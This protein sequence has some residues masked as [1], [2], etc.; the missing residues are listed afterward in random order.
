MQY[1]LM[2]YK[3]T[4]NLGNEIQSI[5][6]RRFLPKIDHYIDHEE[7]H[8]FNN[9]EKVKMIMNGW[10]LDTLEAWPPSSDIDPLLISMHFNTSVNE[11]KDVILSEKSRDFFSSYGPVGCRDPSTLEL[12][13][14]NDIDAYYSGCL[15]LTL[16][17]NN[18][19]YK[20][21]NPYIAVNV[22]KPWQVIKYLKT[23]TDMPIYDVYQLTFNS[24]NEDY[25]KDKPDHYKLT[26]FYT[27][28]E[29]MFQAE[30]FL[31]IYENA[32]CVI[33]DRLHCALPCLAL[34]TPVLFID[35]AQYG[36]ERLGGLTDLVRKATFE[37]YKNDYSIF[38]VE[39]PPK[40]PDDYIKLR[41]DLIKRTKEF[42]GHINDSY[43]MNDSNRLYNNVN[44]LCKTSRKTKKYMRDVDGI[45]NDYQNEIEKQKQTI[46]KQEKI[47]KEMQNSNSWKL[48][49]PLR[50][51]RRL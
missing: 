4:I 20:P 10:Y 50:K 32:S 19:Q 8:L 30:N 42:T 11:T 23:K 29:K 34:N 47:I 18:P 49:G 39:K 44:L 3:K 5:A 21:D 37:D 36:L 24:L 9:P 43:L 27:E 28:E 1:G 17:N 6:A 51:I 41:K 45:I 38:D 7:L 25:I 12:L 26:S 16:D 40:N 2:T 22:F 14:E 15:T 13:Q 46:A 31:T 33:T 35:T 48:T